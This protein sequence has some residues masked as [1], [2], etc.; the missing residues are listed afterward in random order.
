M[1]NSINKIVTSARYSIVESENATKVVALQLENRVKIP[2]D[3][4]H[5]FLVKIGSLYNLSN[6]VFA[7]HIPGY[8]NYMLSSEF[9]WSEPLYH[10]TNDRGIEIYS[11]SAMEV[12]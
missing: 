11:M 5:E 4:K 6:E 8:T 10:S 2:W 1:S 7:P 9:L 3:N 12:A